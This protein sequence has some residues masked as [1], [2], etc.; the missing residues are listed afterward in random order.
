MVS[1]GRLGMF[2]Y[3][4]CVRVAVTWCDPEV[5]GGSAPVCAMRAHQGHE[6]VTLLLALVLATGPGG[7]QDKPALLGEAVLQGDPCQQSRQWP[8]PDLV[9]PTFFIQGHPASPIFLLA[10]TLCSA[11]TSG[12]ALPQETPSGFLSSGEGRWRA[13]TGPGFSHLSFPC[14]K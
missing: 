5:R 6:A 10:P 3:T 11:W 7:G 9:S 4:L 2:S 12:V 1:H 14:L 13:M 8:S